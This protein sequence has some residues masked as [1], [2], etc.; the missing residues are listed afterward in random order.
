V[1]LLIIGLIASQAI[2][3]AVIASERPST[4]EASAVADGL[5]NMGKHASPDVQVTAL[6]PLDR[7]ATAV[8]GAESSHGTDLNMWRPDAS[9]PQGP[10]AGEQGGGAGCR[11]W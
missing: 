9:G 4:S 6:L 2:A 11:R 10:D 8:D 5:K 7:V 3:A 1:R